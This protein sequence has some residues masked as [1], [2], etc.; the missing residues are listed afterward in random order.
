ML[1]C[2]LDVPT[3]QVGSRGVD[4]PVS[5]GK[6]GF[7]EVGAGFGAVLGAAQTY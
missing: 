1:A 3:P 2:C 7:D 4:V 6:D 5:G